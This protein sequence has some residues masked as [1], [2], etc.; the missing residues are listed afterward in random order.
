MYS[1]LLAAKKLDA[2]HLSCQLGEIDIFAKFA[3]FIVMQDMRRI[4][5]EKRTVRHMIE[6]WCRAKHGGNTLC[7]ECQTLLDYSLARLEHCRFGEEKTKCHK[8]AVH[9]YRPEMRARIRE[10]MRYSG[11]RMI[12]CHP[13]EALRYL[14][15][16]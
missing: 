9:C 11:P 2:L 15:S 5:W 14:I 8:C 3:W 10:V 7:E 6:L 12:L 16:R 4:E 13:L 1:V